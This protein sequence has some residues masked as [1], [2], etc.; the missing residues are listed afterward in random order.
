VEIFLSFFK[1]HLVYAKTFEMAAK[2][3]L[4]FGSLKVG[5]FWFDA[6][7]TIPSMIFKE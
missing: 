7:S 6:F 1:G 2:R 4:F 3:Y 5:A